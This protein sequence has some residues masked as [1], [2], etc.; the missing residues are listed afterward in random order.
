MNNRFQLIANKDGQ[1]HIGSLSSL[2]LNIIDLLEKYNLIYVGSPF[3]IDIDFYV[4]RDQWGLSKV[5]WNGKP[6]IALK[7]I[8]SRNVRYKHGILH[9]EDKMYTIINLICSKDKDSKR[10]AR[11]IFMNGLNED[12]LKDMT[13]LV[14]FYPYSWLAS[15]CLLSSYYKFDLDK[16]SLIMLI[17]NHLINEGIFEHPQPFNVEEHVMT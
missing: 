14:E 6:I 10:L 8:I 11:S 7:E 12:D 13:H 9:N 2:N 3:S 16:S 17:L 5:K 1:P 4:C 15:S